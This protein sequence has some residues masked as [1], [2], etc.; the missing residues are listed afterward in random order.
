MPVDLGKRPDKQACVTGCGL[1]NGVV[2]VG[3]GEPRAAFRE[4]R[5]SA[6]ELRS[7]LVEIA[8]AKSVDRDENDERRS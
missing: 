1:G 7:E 5:E 4:S 2:L 8:G 3:V 6:G